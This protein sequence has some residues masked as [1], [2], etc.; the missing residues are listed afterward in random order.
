MKIKA[1]GSKIPG[2]ELNTYSSKEAYGRI[3]VHICSL[4]RWPKYKKALTFG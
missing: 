4:M 3:W 1:G 2:R